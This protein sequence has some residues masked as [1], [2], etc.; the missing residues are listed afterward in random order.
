MVLS[1]ESQ[2]PAIEVQNWL[3]GEALANFQPNYVY[4]LEFFG[5]SCPHCVKAMP[6]LVQ[7]Q[8]RYRARGLEVVG[9]AASEKAATADEAQ[10]NLEAWLTEKSPKSNF[11]IGLDCTGEMRKL[12]MTPS[13]SFHIPTTF[14]VDRDSRIA[15]IGRPTDLDVVL[16]QVLD[17]TWRTSDQAKAIERG[18]IAKGRENLFLR[19]FSAAMKIEDWKTALSVIEEGTALLP[20]SLP[21]RASHADLLLHRMRDMQTGLPVLRQ[22]VR[23]AIDRND[24]DWLL[25]AMNQLFGEF[26]YTDFPSVERLAMGKELSEHIL[27]LTGLKDDARADFYQYVAQ[28]YHE[29][30]NNVRAVEL[31]EFALKLVDGLPLP[32]NIKQPVL[33]DWLHTLADYKG[34]EARSGDVCVV[35]RTN[36][37]SGATP[38]GG[39]DEPG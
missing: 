23:D 24:E 37:S 6:N 11:R 20:D 38:K 16:P 9:V 15:F 3:R 39:E 27:A 35:P 25:Q 2:A 7:L 18:R 30:G 1:L 31:L 29:S 32:D 34:G 13:F 8:E 36:I 12:W 21:L 28:Y 14:V 26:D 10:A 17:G 5:T 33:E 22:L 4:V 19:K